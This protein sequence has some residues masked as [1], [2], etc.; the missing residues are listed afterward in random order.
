MNTAD[1]LS[2]AYSVFEVGSGRV[3][4]YEAIHSNVE[5]EVVDQTSA[6]IDGKEKLIK[7]LTGG[8]SF[9]SYGF[10]DQD[11]TDSRK[12]T[13]KNRSEKV[14]TF[15]VDVN[16]QTGL[17]GS[18]DAAKNNITL[19]GPTSVKLD[20][21]S[22]ENIKF[23]LNIPKTAEKGTYEGYITF[24][25]SQDPTETYQ[26]PFGGRFVDEGIDTFK[27]NNPMFGNNIDWPENAYPY[28]SFSYSLKSYMKT[29]DV[30]LQDAET[31]EDLG[32]VGSY[33][34]IILNENQNYT[35]PRGFNSIYYPFTG[36]AK[37]PIS[38]EPINATAGKYRLK[39]IGT[40]EEGKVFTKTADFFFDAGTPT[41]T[42]SFDNLDQKVI[43]YKDSQFDSNGQFLYDFNINLNDPE[44]AEANGLGIPVDQSSNAVV[45]FYDSPFPAK[46]KYTDKNGNYTDKIKV[47][48]RSTPLNVAF[49]GF[50][51]ARNFTANASNMLEVTFVSENL[52]YYY[53]K[54]NKQTVTTGDT[55]N[56]S[57]R[58]NNVKNL[59]TTKINLKVDPNLAT[60]QNVL[61]N[62]AVKQ[63]GDANVSVSSVPTSVGTLLYTFTFTYNGTKALPEDLLLFN[64]DLKT[65]NKWLKGMPFDW[66]TITASTIDQSNVETSN[67]YTFMETYNKKL[68]Y[69]RVEGTL[70]LEGTVDPTTGQ[71]NYALDESKIGAKVTVTSY[72]GKTMVDAPI[73]NQNGQYTAEGLKADLKPYT[74]K[75]DV[76]GH[77]T[78]YRKMNLA[79]EVRGELVGKRMVWNLTQAAAGDVNKDNVIDILDA[80]AVQTY[81]GTN[82]ATA[83]F[84]FDKVVDKKDMYYIVKNFGLQNSTV[85]NSP[86]PKTTYKGKTLDN[87][88]KDL[89][90]DQ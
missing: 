86:K 71:Q 61:V 28:I 27:I 2:K 84:N 53:L 11:V 78:M 23:N 62:D 63:Y 30:V 67:V 6:G 24:T 79:D 34:P 59:K 43:E 47:K 21:N 77:F 8:I 17:R 40:N 52:P 82:K 42:T 5:L 66:N 50:D 37:N 45:S 13:L 16:F 22:Q 90:L 60:I 51:A 73:Y 44:T 19:T 48:K 15:N 20:G 49:Y 83:D 69:S 72:D 10:D 12:I 39:M 46:P 33:V 64:F 3:D 75:V 35:N 68:T 55:V 89:G 81:W 56:Y 31:G 14:K 54:A 57:I 9:G 7:E 18:K 26:I 65:A 25:N 4:A 36:D 76:P 87:I 41:M 32:L 38:S 80:I 58:S 29:L 85:D 74:V 88:L 1:P 70:R